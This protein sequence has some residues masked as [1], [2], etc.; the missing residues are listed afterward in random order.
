MDTLDSQTGKIY[1]SITT[2]LSVVLITIYTSTKYYNACNISGYVHIITTYTT[3]LNNVKQSARKPLI[4]HCTLITANLVLNRRTIIDVERGNI[5]MKY[6][7]V[8]G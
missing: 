2:K 3:W 4:H 8:Q 5:Q 6:L 1:S 7:Q